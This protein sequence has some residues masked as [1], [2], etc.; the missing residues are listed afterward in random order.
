MS[1]YAQLALTASLGAAMTFAGTG[2]PAQRF[3]DPSLAVK[4]V[5][6]LIALARSK[7]VIARLDAALSKAV[8]APDVRERFVA[9]GV[10]PQTRASAEMTRY[11]KTEI[12]KYG[13]IVKVIGLKID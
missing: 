12:D 3:I 10:E 5:K 7:D 4:S 1:K 11:L 2:A 9:L 8:N 6:E 13:K